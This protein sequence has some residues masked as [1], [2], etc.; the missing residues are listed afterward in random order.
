MPRYLISLLYP[1]VDCRAM[2][3]AVFLA[4]SPVVIAVSDDSRRAMQGVEMA[5]KST[6]VQRTE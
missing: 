6:T 1:C 2:G 5:G 3:S 4:L